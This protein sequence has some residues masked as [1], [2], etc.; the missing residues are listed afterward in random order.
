MIIN[1]IDQSNTPRQ[2][3]GVFDY[4]KKT[5]GWEIGL[6]VVVVAAVIQNGFFPGPAKYQTMKPI[7]G[8]KNTTKAQI[9]FSTVFAEL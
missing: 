4:I 1:R 8:R 9:N 6:D 7:N 2:S 5:K 3:R